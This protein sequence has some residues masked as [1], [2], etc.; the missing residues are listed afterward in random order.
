[1][2]VREPYPLIASS[3]GLTLARR[4]DLLAGTKVTGQLHRSLNHPIA[5]H[6]PGKATDSEEGLTDTDNPLGTRTRNM[7]LPSGAETRHL[8]PPV[9]NSPGLPISH[10]HKQRDPWQTEILYSAADTGTAAYP[11]KTDKEGSTS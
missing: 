9:R 5:T 3:G 2:P 6:T 4:L 10:Q 11:E 1:M 8:L 7:M